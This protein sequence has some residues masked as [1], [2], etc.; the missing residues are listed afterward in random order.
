[1][2]D[3]HCTVTVSTEH[4]DCEHLVVN[5]LEGCKCLN[6]LKIDLTEK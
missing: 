5:P 3:G 6:L 1:M 2:T 4:C